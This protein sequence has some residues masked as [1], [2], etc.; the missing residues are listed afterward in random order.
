[1]TPLLRLTLHYRK[2]A[3]GKGLGWAR[4]IPEPNRGGGRLGQI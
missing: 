2:G 4:H 3:W 1:M